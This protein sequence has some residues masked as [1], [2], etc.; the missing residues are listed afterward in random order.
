VK[1]PDY[2]EAIIGWRVW[3]QFPH[4][5]LGSPY[6]GGLWPAIHDVPWARRVT[7]EVY[8]W[9]RI[10]RHELGYR[11]VFAYP[12]ILYVPARLL[13]TLRMQKLKGCYGV[14]LSAEPLTI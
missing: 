9:G 8:L 4:G 7:G 13:Y 12:K 10:I 2:V 11:A 14:P 1:T 3:G 5:L 6:G